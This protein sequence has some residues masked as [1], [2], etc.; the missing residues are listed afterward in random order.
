[1]PGPGLRERKKEQTR[2]AIADTAVALFAQRGFEAVTVA[3][4]AEAANVAPQT[5]FNYFPTKEDLV[6][7]TFDESVPQRFADAVRCCPPGQSVIAAVRPLVFEHFDHALATEDFEAVATTAQLIEA[8]PALQ[9]RQR[10]DAARF[11]GSLTAAIAETFGA[12]PTDIE[13]LLVGYAT[14]SIYE[15]VFEIARRRVLSGQRGRR[16]RTALRSDAERCW[17]LTERGL[18]DYKRPDADRRADRRPSPGN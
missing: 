16:L 6:L 11:A 8:S 9:A 4:I 17:T 2:Q 10:A 14:I 5:V 15:A 1:M 13:P 18:G 3:Q 12:S 7:G